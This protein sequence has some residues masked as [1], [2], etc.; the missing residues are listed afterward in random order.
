MGKYQFYYKSFLIVLFVIAGN[1]TLSAQITEH[2]SLSPEKY[3]IKDTT[4][5]FSEA[6]FYGT[7]QVIH[8][9]KNHEIFTKA[10]YY[11]IEARRDDSEVVLWDISP[12]TTIRIFPRNLIF[13]PTNYRVNEHEI[14]DEN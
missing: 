12:L 7:F 14:T 8:H 13:P 9:S 2:E 4:Q 6:N 10:S 11:E 1:L 3:I 5:Y